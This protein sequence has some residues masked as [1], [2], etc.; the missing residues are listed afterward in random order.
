MHIHWLPDGRIV[1]ME[2][3]GDLWRAYNQIDPVDGS[4]SRLPIDE[5]GGTLFQLAMAPDGNSL[6][7]AGNRGGYYEVKV[8]LVDLADGSERLLY[9]GRAAPFAWSADARWVYLVTEEPSVSGDERQSRI[10]RVAVASGAVEF[11]ADLPEPAE[12][13]SHI[14][15]SRDELNIVYIQRRSGRDLWLMD[16]KPIRN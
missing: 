9:D 7:V 10:L 11:V 4:I 16:I 6:A 2:R 1:Y 3:D 14:D 13:W 12:G 8:W 15:L 5:A